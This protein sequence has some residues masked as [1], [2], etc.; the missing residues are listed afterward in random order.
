MIHKSVLFFAVLFF[1]TTSCNNDPNDENPKFEENQLVGR[2]E[3]V[4]A[5]RNGKKT[6]TLTDTFYEFSK[7]GQMTTNLTPTATEENFPYQFTGSEIKQEGGAETVFKVE[8]LNDT[9]LTMSMMIMKFPF[10]LVLAKAELE[11]MEAAQPREEGI[12]Q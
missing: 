3:I 8:N 2:W 9:S 4:E 10:K 11:A 7:E 12:P 6:E 5:F 1:V